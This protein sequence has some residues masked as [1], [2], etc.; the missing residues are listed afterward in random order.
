M[1][2]VLRQ[3]R[4]REEEDGTQNSSPIPPH[5]LATVLKQCGWFTDVG[6]FGAVHDFFGR[7]SER[8]FFLV[9]YRVYHTLLTWVWKNNC[10]HIS[11]KASHAH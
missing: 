6:V 8:A 11:A 9:V 2:T 4:F 3:K 5:H 7:V 10:I 1:D